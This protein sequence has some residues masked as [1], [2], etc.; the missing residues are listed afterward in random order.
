MEV[1]Y[2]TSHGKKIMQ[3]NAIPEFTDETL[4]SVLIIAHDITERKQSE[5]EIQDKNKKISESINYSKR[6]QTAVIPN[7]KII[8]EIFPN[9]YVFYQPRDVVSGDF[10]W[11]MTKNDSVYVAAV[12]CTGHGVPGAML[13]LVGSFLLNEIVRYGDEKDPAT[14]LDMLDRMVNTS[15]NTDKNES[16]IKDGMDIALCKINLQNNTLQYAGAHR[17]LL[18]VREGTLTEYKGDRW[19]I[20]GGIYKNQTH[21]TN[22]CLNIKQGDCVHIF[23]DGLVDQFGG[24]NSKKLG[25][26]RIK[27]LVA[28]NWKDIMICGEKIK[29]EFN[30]WKGAQKQTD[31]VIMIGIKF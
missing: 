30:S 10:P 18:H 17:P 12:D 4:E 13:S 7:S 2:N 6:I 24:P 11:L 9:A 26:A 1:V 21:F 22:H 5:L 8:N 28:S 16:S 19:A 15:L 23:S 31:D 14:I 25:L 29:S 27:E 3:L 20:G